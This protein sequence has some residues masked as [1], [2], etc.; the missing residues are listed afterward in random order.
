MLLESAVLT[1]AVL[2]A[3]ISINEVPPPPRFVELTLEGTIGTDI[4]AHGLERAISRRMISKIDY[5]VLHV[6]SMGGFL[7]E[8][9]RIL[10]ILKAIDQ[11]PEI[12]VIIDGDA[13][14]AAIIF[15]I[16][17][18]HLYVASD[19]SFGAAV[20]Y[21]RD[22][23]TGSVEVDA[24]FN[25]AIAARF[26]T[27][28]ENHGW[29]A[30]LIRATVERDRELFTWVDENGIRRFGEKVPADSP[31]L[32][33]DSS[34]T[35]LTLTSNEL[36]DLGLAKGYR[37]IDGVRGDLG[38]DR[39]LDVGRGPQR[40]FERIAAERRHLMRQWVGTAQ[41]ITDSLIRA[42]EA[43]PRNH[44][45]YYNAVSGL[46]TVD[47]QIAW[48]K[49]ADECISHWRHVQSLL[50]TL[51]QIE[52]DLRRNGADWFVEKQTSGGHWGEAIWLQSVRELDWLLANRTRYRIDRER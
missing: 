26:A 17:A 43:D 6:D 16:V 48:R 30:C 15:P 7:V 45:V 40:I 37:G 3:C 14:S 27:V 32:Q 9:E 38:L 44:D 8:A 35:I 1:V 29:P 19:A 4:T 5:V 47:S 36:V 24:K 23:S 10:N 11:G 41:N 20:A 52:N 31:Y 34:R 39:W 22:D 42:K 21:S 13:L 18:D 25:S 49:R 28:A 12:V 46:L 50:R 51:A 2:G 33:L